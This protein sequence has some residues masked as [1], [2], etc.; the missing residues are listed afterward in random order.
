M[1]LLLRN[2]LAIVKGYSKFS[3]FMLVKV[4]QI[5]ILAIGDFNIVYAVETD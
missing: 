1:A 2:Q 3:S 4:P 5:S